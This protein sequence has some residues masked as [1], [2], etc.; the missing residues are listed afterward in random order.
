MDLLVKHIPIDHSLTLIL[1]IS[2]RSVSIITLSPGVINYVPITPLHF[3]LKH[4]ICRHRTVPQHH[5][6]RRVSSRPLLY[7][8]YM[9][10]SP[11]ISEIS[12]NCRDNKFTGLFLIRW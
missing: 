6:H 8:R 12:L 5:L 10:V 4:R 7:E 3:N 11:F 9:N 1:I 2:R